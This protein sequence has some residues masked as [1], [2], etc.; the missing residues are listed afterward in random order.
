MTLLTF[1]HRLLPLPL[2]L[3]CLTVQERRDS[4]LSDLWAI[5]MLFPL[6]GVLS[7]SGW[8]DELL[9]IIE[10]FLRHFLSEACPDCPTLD[11]VPVS[12]GVLLAEHNRTL[13]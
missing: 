11:E 10:G 9:L 4:V 2:T 13:D 1:P 8:T 7:P 6:S 12:I 5:V 3:M